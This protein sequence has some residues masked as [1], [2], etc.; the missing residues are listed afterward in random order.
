[1]AIWFRRLTAVDGNAG[2]VGI[3]LISKSQK[4][5]YSIKLGYFWDVFV[6]E[7]GSIAG[8]VTERQGKNNQKEQGL[9][10]QD[11][12]ACFIINIIV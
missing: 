6:L 11:V 1:M 8:Y 7:R 2:F 10:I 3:T 12:S 9:Y 5:M 4:L